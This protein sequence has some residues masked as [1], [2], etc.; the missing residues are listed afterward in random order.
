MTFPKGMK[1]SSPLS[2]FLSSSLSRISRFFVS[3]TSSF[4]FVRPTSRPV[5]LTHLQP[6]L[7]LSYVPYSATW[8]DQFLRRV[9]PR[10]S[11]KRIAVRS[12]EKER[13]GSLKSVNLESEAGQRGAR[14]FSRLTGAK[15]QSERESERD[16][17][18]RDRVGRRKGVEARRRHST[19]LFELMR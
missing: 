19:A 12:R 1:E 8:N 13:H 15:K 10:P 5:F 7:S 2:L 9:Q 4:Q 11:T 16:R 3:I 14:V 18:N 17:R 6:P